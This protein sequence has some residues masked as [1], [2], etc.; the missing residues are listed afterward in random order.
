MKAGS[1]GAL[2]ALALLVA[3]AFASAEWTQLGYDAART[4][5]TPEHGPL[6][7]DVAWTERL[8]GSVAYYSPPLLMNGSLF[9]MSADAKNYGLNGELTLDNNGV[10]KV[11]ATTGAAKLFIKTRDGPGH[12]FSDGSR[13]YLLVD[14]GA[15]A[16]DASSGHQIWRWTPPNLMTTVYYNLCYNGAARG[17]TLYLVC[18]QYG[19]ESPSPGSVVQ[20]TAFVSA[21]TRS[22]AKT[23]W[24]WIENPLLEAANPS[25]APL[26][27]NPLGGGMTAP[28]AQSASDTSF[29][30]AVSVIGSNV[31]AITNEDHFTPPFTAKAPDPA[32]TVQYSETVWALDAANGYPL[33]ARNSTLEQGAFTPVPGGSFYEND[34]ALSSQITGTATA[35]YFQLDGELY[36]ANAGT[37]KTI[38][39]V[40]LGAEDSFGGSCLPGAG[41]TTGGGIGGSALSG[42]TLFATSW[43]TLY[44]FNTTSRSLV[45]RYT[46]PPDAYMYWNPDGVIV[47]G[48]TVYALAE[49]AYGGNLSREGVL[50]ALDF[51]DGRVLWRHELP[52]LTKDGYTST[53]QMF[54][55]SDHLLAVGGIDGTLTLFGTT[56]ACLVASVDAASLYPEPGK[57]FTVDLSKTAPGIGGPAN[58]Y[59]VDWGDGG[60]AGWQPSAKLT[61]TYA[62]AGDA[63]AHFV[64]RNAANQTASQMVTFHVGASPPQQLT[65][66][67]VAFAPENQNLTFFVIGVVLTAVGALF[68][69]LRL[70]HR[71][72]RLAREIKAVDDVYARTRDNPTECE[73]A[74]AHRKARAHELLFE[75]K[76]EDGHVGILENHIDQ[77]ARTVRL[78]QLDGR[79]DFLPHGMVKTLQKMLA[80]GEISAWEYHH[81]ISVLDADVTLTP[82]QKSQVRALIEEWY[83]HDSAVGAFAG[84]AKSAARS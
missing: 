7:D 24:T 61:H 63:V 77:L 62:T 66:L 41:C 19:S 17:N 32:G 30:I 6:T 23:V 58:A 18:T 34:P 21:V 79:F 49:R 1:V 25:T 72:S 12:L 76:L 56:A 53:R 64:V 73:A 69:L 22:D 10:Y 45:W 50:Y 54:S 33:W 26:V 35:V 47:A 52:S 8:N 83:A 71:R 44:R 74:L 55:V 13:L 42:D 11:N 59:R 81:F 9:V 40:P 43:Q 65:A 46:L 29:G 75:G 28:P 2:L 15:E 48:S 51:Q 78:S 82:M 80:D 4:S 38:W 60:S 68:G 5:A 84:R 16:Y 20:I 3:P 27:A 39:S 70:R 57:P 14:G 31:F 37:G 67:Q 36:A